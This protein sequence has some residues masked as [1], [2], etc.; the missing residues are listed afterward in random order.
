MS[1]HRW[2]HLCLK[3]RVSLVGGGRAC[4]P[5]ELTIKLLSKSNLLG[6]TS[7][8]N[9]QCSKP[10]NTV[11]SWPQKN[12]EMDH[13]KIEITKFS[14]IPIVRLPHNLFRTRIIFS[15]CLHML[16]CLRHS[17]QI[18][19]VCHF[20]ILHFPSPST[21]S[22]STCPHSLSFSSFSPHFLAIRSPDPDRLCQ[23]AM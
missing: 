22:A 19:R 8:L 11:S 17:R 13:H 10:Y 14:S 23:P 7:L 1:W 3:A 16:K 4:Q 18:N 9:I 2:F 15:K 5:N 21:S 12:Y 20:L 6:F